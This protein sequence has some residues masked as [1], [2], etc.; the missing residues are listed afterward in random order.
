MV[1][2]NVDGYTFQKWTENGNDVSTGASYQFTVTGDRNLVAEY[3]QNPIYYTISVSTSPPNLNPQPTGGGQYASGVTATVVAQN[4]DGYTF[5]KWTENGNDVS[6]GASYQFTVTGDRNLV[7][8]YIQ[9]QLSAI[10]VSIPNGGENWE[11]GTTN[12]ISWTSTGNTGPYVK[13]ELLKG[14]NRYRLISYSTEND[15]SYDWKIPLIRT[16][17]DYKI[18]IT[19]TSNPI[20]TDTSDNDF[21]ISSPTSCHCI[22]LDVQPVITKSEGS[23]TNIT[24]NVTLGDPDSD[25]TTRSADIEID[26]DW[27]IN[28]LCAGAKG[29]CSATITPTITSNLKIGNVGTTQ[30]SQSNTPTSITCN[31]KCDTIVHPTQNTGNGH[32]KSMITVHRNSGGQINGKSISGTVTVTMNSDCPIK[33]KTTTL[34]I[35]G[36]V[37]ESK[38]PA[39]VNGVNIK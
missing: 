11:I 32:T 31:G 2:Q 19:S 25:G 8:E 1:A 10:Y 26:I 24:A 16:G 7:A 13:I 18:R 12:T 29:S 21:A 15:G 6:T 34:R 33:K 38:S 4:V 5:Q 3:I 30:T 14:G 39:K 37:T 22:E 36:T 9:D 35:S 23:Y 20:Y 27:I 28:M 17:A